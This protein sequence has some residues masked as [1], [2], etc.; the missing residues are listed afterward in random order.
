M[1]INVYLVYVHVLSVPYKQNNFQC[2]KTQ[3]WEWW[4]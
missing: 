4:N 2:V 3:D 1:N